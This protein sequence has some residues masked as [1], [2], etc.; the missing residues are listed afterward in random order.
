MDYHL[1]LRI[2]KHAGQAWVNDK[3]PTLGAALAYY[4]VFSIAPILFLA[5]GIAGLVF[6][7]QAA[8][9]EIIEQIGGTVGEPAAKAIQNVLTNVEQ[10]GGGVKFTIIGVVILLFT[11]SGVFAQ[12][13]ESLNVIWKAE[14][15][16]KG[17]TW[18]TL[19]RDRLLSFAAVLGTGFLLLVS[20]VISSALEALNKWLT[21]QSMPGGAY[22]WM[23]IN[24]LVSLAFITLL[25]AL[26]FKWLPDTPVAW[27]DVWAGAILAALAFSIGK[28]LIGL[29]LGKVS[30]AS[31][32][33]A[34]GS[35]VVILVWV[36]Y[37]SQI[38]LFGAEVTHSFAVLAGSKQ[39]SGNKG[40]E[41]EKPANRMEHA[42]V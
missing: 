20:L 29:Y 18:W 13:Q 14:D 1:W 17:S 10:S 3:V 37:S 4:T 32:F 8:R 9:G 33:G 15:N 38:I 42:H 25:F 7:P 11:A 12:L 27:R 34:A 5:I 30:V 19:I 35:L 36:Y 39:E 24:F 28:W 23:G 21:P 40:Q 31:T 22:L 26:I 41:S 16:K 2:F 6:G